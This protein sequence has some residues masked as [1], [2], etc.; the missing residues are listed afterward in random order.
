LSNVIRNSQVSVSNPI[1]VN[2]K[3]LLEKLFQAKQEYLEVEE[4]LKQSSEQLED[5]AKK[6]QDIELQVK[7]IIE[8]ARKEAKTII[9]NAL[10]EKDK[11]INENF[12]KGY[13]EGFEKGYAEGKEKAL[14]E[15]EHLKSELELT[16]LQIFSKHDEMLKKAQEELFLILPKLIEKIIECE[17]EDN[18]YLVKYIKNAIEQL[19]IRNNLTIRLS[20]DDYDF[21]SINLS[22]II[23]GIEGINNIDIKTDI[24]LKKGDIIVETPY[25]IIET[26]LNMRIKKIEDIIKHLIGD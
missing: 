15:I 4:K 24:S 26:G 8:N 23:E 17:I 22:N 25:G 6:K 19:S 5:I 7:E 1:E 12:N 16:K 2:Y 20:K 11:I 18:K 10:K 3:V 14:I 9:D 13:N 21:V